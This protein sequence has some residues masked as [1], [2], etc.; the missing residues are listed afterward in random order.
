M[1]EFHIWTIPII[2]TITLAYSIL[3]KYTSIFHGK[4]PPSS[5]PNY[6]NSEAGHGLRPSSGQARLAQSA[7]KRPRPASAPR[8]GQVRPDGIDTSG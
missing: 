7:E 8:F 3:S 1:V 5:R 2:Q 4:C 6:V